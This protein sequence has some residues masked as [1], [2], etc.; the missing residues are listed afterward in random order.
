M[1]ERAKTSGSN[2]PRTADIRLAIRAIPRF[3]TCGG[4]Q[5]FGEKYPHVECLLADRVSENHGE[6][7]LGLYHLIHRAAR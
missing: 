7:G 4:R 2:S 3:A 1:M 5:A 6:H